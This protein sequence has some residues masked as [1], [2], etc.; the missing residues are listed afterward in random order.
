MESDD[1]YRKA[2]RYDLRAQA[3]NRRVFHRHLLARPWQALVCA[4]GMSLLGANAAF[5]WVD[6]PAWH[7]QPWQGWLLGNIVFLIAAYFLTCALLGWQ[8]RHS[9]RT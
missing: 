2:S 3:H 8:R 1:V 5:N 9:S 7:R 4:I 6:A